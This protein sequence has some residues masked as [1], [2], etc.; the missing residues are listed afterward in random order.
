MSLYADILRGE[1]IDED[2]AVRQDGESWTVCSWVIE[3]DV[4]PGFPSQEMALSVAR[5][6]RHAYFEGVAAAQ[7]S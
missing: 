4:I 1:W 5:A 2:D 6:I 7:Y 3:P